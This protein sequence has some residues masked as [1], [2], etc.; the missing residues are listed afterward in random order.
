MAKNYT[1]T[2]RPPTI[3]GYCCYFRKQATVLCFILFLPFFAYSAK[4]YA[5]ASLIKVKGVVTDENGVPISEAKLY[6]QVFFVFNI[7]ED[8]LHLADQIKTLAQTDSNGTFS[9]DCSN[10]GPG[11]LFFVAAKKLTKLGVFRSSRED[12]EKVHTVTLADSAWI[13]TTFKSKSTTFN[14]F[15]IKLLYQETSITGRKST[16][17]FMAVDYILEDA[18]DS[19]SVNIPC[20]SGCKL[21]LKIVGDPQQNY[22]MDIPSLKPGEVF[23]LGTQLFEPKRKNNKEPPELQI[24]EWVKGKPTTL[25][26]LKG[27]VVLLDFWGLW[28]GPCIQKFPELVRLHAKYSKDGLVIIGIHDPSRTKQDLIDCN[29]DRLNMSAIPFRIAID[30]PDAPSFNSSSGA[31]GQGKTINAY[32][33]TKFPTT[34]LIDKSGNIDS[35]ATPDLEDRIQ[36]LLYGKKLSL[37]QN[38]S[39]DILLIRLCLLGL[40]GIA[41]FLGIK[42]VKYTA[43]Q[44]R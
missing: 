44:K 7:F 34:V 1:K 8:N 35:Y 11:V 43:K 29:P 10:R 23:N 4:V 12:L 32:G 24:N 33:I 41:I 2:K 14:T 36:L 9:V 22:S 38:V 20:P 30:L 15:T 13:K 16:F 27:K 17:D 37:T 40:V 25:E 26:T 3:S 39:H 5:D 19:I 6:P 18:L 21:A 28:C 42:V 31:I